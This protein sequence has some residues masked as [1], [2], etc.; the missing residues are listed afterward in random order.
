MGKSKRHM[1]SF[2]LNTECNLS[3]SYCYV[4]NCGI[5]QIL[6]FEFAKR[7]ID[8]FFENDPSRWIRFYSAGEPTLEF[9]LMRKIRDYAYEKSG[10][11]LKVELQ[12]NGCFSTKVRDW[13]SENGTIIWLSWDGT[14]E[15]HDIFRKFHDGRP[16]SATIEKNAKYLVKNAK[17]VVG[18]RATIGVENL[19][20]QKEMIKYF[21]KFG[22][23]HVWSDPVFPQV[24]KNAAFGQNRTIDLMEYAKEFLEAQKTAEEL[25]IFYG[26]ILTQNFDEKTI[27]NCSACLPM[28]H[29]TTDGYVSA[30]DMALFGKNEEM[31]D[32]IYG[33]WDDK[34]KKIIY[35][36]E[37]IKKLRSRSADNM[38]GCN[39]CEAIAH[40]AGY[41]LGEVLNEQRCIFGKKKVVCEPIRYLFKNMSI[42]SGAYELCHP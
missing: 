7:G 12:T 35:D 38:P 36:I 40:C 4:P 10:D 16:T 26:S 8:D 39:S 42:D 22:I 21:S 9:E 27:Y 33:K 15:V 1:I 24:R 25:G 20:F 18:V 34:S 32:L 5:K 29:L 2:F 30:C 37:K 19:Y 23:E 3:C 13:L 17:G 14:P 11:T 28:P 6:N 31:N 41:C